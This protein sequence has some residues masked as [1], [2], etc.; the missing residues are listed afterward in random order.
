MVWHNSGGSSICKSVYEALSSGVI[1]PYSVRV[2]VVRTPRENVLHISEMVP[3]FA[4]AKHRDA[5]VASAGGNT[6]LGVHGRAYGWLWH[7]CCLC[8]ARQH[9]KAAGIAAA[10]AAL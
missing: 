6:L 4:G 2:F 9:G 1:E 3:E 10:G 7:T 5:S 8:R